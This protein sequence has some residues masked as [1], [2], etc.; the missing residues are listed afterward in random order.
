MNLRLALSED[1]RLWDDFVDNSRQG[2]IFCKSAFMAALG[3][4]VERWLL[5]EDDRAV[6]AYPVLLESRGTPA[7]APHAY[8]M[9][10]GLMFHES[11]DEQALHRRV[12]H[13]LKLTDFLLEEL[14][15]R[16]PRISL[17]THPN[18]DDIRSFL[19]F[20]YHSTDKGIFQVH[21]R[22]TGLLSLASFEQQSFL[23]Q[24]RSLRKR[25]FVRATKDGYQIT[26][27]QDVATLD[28]LHGLTFE[29]QGLTRS[30]TDVVLLQDIAEAA[31]KHKFGR[32]MTA[33]SSNGEIAS[34][35]LILFDK[36]TAYYLFGAN[37]PDFRSSGASTYLMCAAIDAAAKEGLEYFDFVG[38]NSPD[39]G[40]YKVSFN[41]RPVPYHTLDWQKPVAF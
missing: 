38:I 5:S 14:S 18:L 6:A 1:D 41:A 22:Y 11:V 3:K 24:V 10:Q 37:D 15:A 39:R 23:S 12:Q 30:D 35:N 29:R 25:E 36:R 34:A 33:V 4:Q 13:K 28:R 27:S 9:Y 32:C 20:N 19:W 16:Y 31:L 17:C 26:E 2:S 7:F 8:T 40:D 21:T